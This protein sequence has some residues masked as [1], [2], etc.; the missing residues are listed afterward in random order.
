MI[1]LAIVGLALVVGLSFAIAQTRVIIL[2]KPGDTAGKVLL[3]NGVDHI[4]LINATDRLCRAR[5]C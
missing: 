3:V 2:A 5:G 1:R 4:L